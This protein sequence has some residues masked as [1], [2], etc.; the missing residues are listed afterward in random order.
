[1]IGRI[2]KQMVNTGALEGKAVPSS[3]KTTAV[4]RIHNN[5]FLEQAL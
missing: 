5:P 1:V 2:K 4:V 3:Y